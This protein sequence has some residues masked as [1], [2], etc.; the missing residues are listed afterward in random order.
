MPF[1]IDPAEIQKTEIK[2]GVTFPLEFKT[3]MSKNNGGELEA[4]AD[5]WQLI[6]FLDTT[7]RKRL[8][9]TCN[10]IVRETETMR[11]WRGF[12][13]DAFVIAGN[14]AGD[15]LILRLSSAGDT[16]LGERIYRWAHETGEVSFVAENIDECG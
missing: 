14:A 12:P 11:S 13:Q 4:D 7:D 15:Y 3:F 8:A 6:P 5:D 10:D 2:L 1:P 9:R 16:M